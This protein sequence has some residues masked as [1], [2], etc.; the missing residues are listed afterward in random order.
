MIVIGDSTPLNC[1]ILIHQV[2]S[3]RNSSIAF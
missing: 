3:F 1:L 2:D